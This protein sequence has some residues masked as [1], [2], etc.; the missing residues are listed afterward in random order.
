VG[1]QVRESPPAAAEDAEAPP[2]EETAEAVHP[3]RCTRHFWRW[4]ARKRLE[5]YRHESLAGAAAPVR[6]RNALEPEYAQH[7]SA[8]IQHGPEGHVILAAR[9]VALDRGVVM[10]RGERRVNAQDALRVARIR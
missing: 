9:G 10:P 7:A 5:R 3:L 6:A 8:G 1:A 4:G 2:A